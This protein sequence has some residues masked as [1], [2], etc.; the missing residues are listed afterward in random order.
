[1]YSVERVWSI[2]TLIDRPNPLAKLPIYLSMASIPLTYGPVQTMIFY[3]HDQD[4][5]YDPRPPSLVYYRD[6]I[7]PSKTSCCSSTPNSLAIS[8]ILASISSS[9][10]PPKPRIWRTL[11]K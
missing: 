5:L 1:M 2:P 10:P 8:F 9:I 7:Q 3:I 11:K 4:K 6:V